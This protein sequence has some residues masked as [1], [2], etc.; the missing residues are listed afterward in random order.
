MEFVNNDFYIDF[1]FEL[2]MKQMTAF[3]KPES[4]II[5]NLNALF[6]ALLLIRH[7]NR[8]ARKPVVAKS[9]LTTKLSY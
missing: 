2:L 3:D 1:R 8:Q 9:Y 5:S 6:Q 4:G 7:A